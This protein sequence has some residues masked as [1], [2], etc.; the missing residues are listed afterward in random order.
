MLLQQ[1]GRTAALR[2]LLT[3]E[4]KRGSEFEKLANALAAL[5]PRETEERRL[6][7]AMLLAMPK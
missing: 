5:Y 1:G 4:K 6:V 7:E 2:N 3:E